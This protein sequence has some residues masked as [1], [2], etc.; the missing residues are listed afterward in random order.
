MIEKVG[1]PVAQLKLYYIRGMTYVGLLNT[2]AIMILMLNSFYSKINSIGIP[3][4]LLFIIAAVTMVIL[5]GVL[6][7]IDWR[8][9][10]KHENNL[11]VR[12]TPI[13]MDMCQRIDEIDKKL[14]KLIGEKKE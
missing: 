2:V 9:I 8:V 6:G 12:Q 7:Y 1:K 10:C 13:T 14:D 3:M 4:S 5:P 11:S